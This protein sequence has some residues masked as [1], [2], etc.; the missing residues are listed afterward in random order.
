MEPASPEQIQT[1]QEMHDNSSDEQI[2]T[3]LQLDKRIE[4]KG[5]KEAADTLVVKGI[6]YDKAFGTLVRA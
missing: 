1:S 3:K 4:E 6:Q 5:K 2:E